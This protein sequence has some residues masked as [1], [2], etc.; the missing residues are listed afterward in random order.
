MKKFYSLA[1]AENGPAVLRIDG[2]IAGDGWG[3]DDSATEPRAFRALLKPL[4][5][6]VVEINSPGGDVFAAADIYSAL[7]DHPGHVTVRVTGIA[8]SAASVIAMA[9][10]QV[11][12]SPAG[13]I[14][15]HDPWTYAI[16]NARDMEKEA[17]TLREIAEGIVEAYQL[18]TGLPSDEIRRMMEDETF[19]NASR[20][21]ELGFADGYLGG[22]PEQAAP[23]ASMKGRRYTPQAYAA[24]LRDPINKAS[25]IPVDQ[26]SMR[27]RARAAAIAAL[28]TITFDQI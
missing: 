14:M 10:K 22:A 26:K 17:R 1:T 8:A 6:V 16:G 27:T 3:W 20:A 4:S 11:L 15:I 18:K 12:I 23:A 9:G 13:Y 7:M 2:E 19:M 5:D 21:I 25:L 24:R 28:S